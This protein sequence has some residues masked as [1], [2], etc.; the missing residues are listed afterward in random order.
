M[1]KDALGDRMKMYENVES[2]RRFMPL[3]PIVARLDGMG[4]S[5]FTK[6]MERPFD[7]RMSYA[8]IETAKRLLEETHAV[9]AY[10]QSDEI[11]L[12]WYSDSLK[13]QVWFDGRILKMNTALAAKASVI[14]N[15]IIAERLPEY[16]H[17][18]PAFDCRAFNMPNLEE[19]ANNFLWRER[20]AT[21]NSISMAA[22][23]YY[24][25]KQVLGKNGKE[26]L[27]ML[28]E[29]GINWNHYPAFFKRGTFIQ[30]RVIETPYTFDEIDKLPEKHHARTNPDL[31]LRRNI[32]YEFKG[33]FA[34][35]VFDKVT[36]RAD[37]IFNGT[38]P[39]V[40]ADK[41]NKNE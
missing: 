25:H 3:L 22:T 18:D 24:S 34:M 9:C 32:V 15:N 16:K 1:S 6:G 33:D 26:R 23:A 31:K 13:S 20:D 17:K 36:N 4:F 37:V 41:E 8:M 7:R 19:A 12:A 35:P 39:I 38:D 10:T 2:D 30:R 40:V 21:K 27:D 28:M 14:F 5:K 11:T 29:K